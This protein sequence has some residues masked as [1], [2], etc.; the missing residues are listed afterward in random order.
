METVD[1]LVERPFGCDE[2]DRLWVADSTEHPTREGKLSCAVVLDV[3]S[4]LV[5]G[6]LIDA[7]PTA[8]L[9]TNTLGMAID[10]RGPDRTVIL[11]DVGTQ[12]SSRACSRWALDSWPLPSIGAVGGCDDNAMIES[13]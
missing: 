12:L 7:S 2:P 11:C 5:V 13:C 1:K 4:R 8:A 3:W 10:Q 9:V 6:W